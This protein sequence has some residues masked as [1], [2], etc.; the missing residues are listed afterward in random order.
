MLSRRQPGAGRKPGGVCRTRNAGGNRHSSAQRASGRWATGC[1]HI[2]LWGDWL[3]ARGGIGCRH[4]A[5][6]MAYHPVCP[7]TK[8]MYAAGD[9]CAAWRP[10]HLNQRASLLHAVQVA[11]EI[12]SDA[13][14]F[15]SP[16]SSSDAMIRDEQARTAAAVHA[17]CSSACCGYCNV[18]SNQAGLAVFVHAR[19]C[20]HV[21]DATVR[22][23]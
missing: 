14:D 21:C 10:S 23:R 18:C 15:P 4:V 19:N 8:A 1:T 22:R 20:L 5:L 2:V 16:V 13:L 7:T 3:Q 12:F 6:C 9:C 17:C 11:G